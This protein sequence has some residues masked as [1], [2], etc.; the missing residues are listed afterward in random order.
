MPAVLF[1]ICKLK[2]MTSL[3]IHL[4]QVILQKIAES[5]K[6]LPPTLEIYVYDQTKRTT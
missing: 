3:Y 4:K 2:V 6:M 5:A 1:S